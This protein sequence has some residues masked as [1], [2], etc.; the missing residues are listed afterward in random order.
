M[1]VLESAFSTDIPAGTNFALARNNSAF[2]HSHTIRNI[3]VIKWLAKSQSKR[4]PYMLLAMLPKEENKNAA[5]NGPQLSQPGRGIDGSFSVF[6]PDL[7][8]A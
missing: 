6:G 1:A 5:N 7:V 4:C 2:F 3:L 8:S